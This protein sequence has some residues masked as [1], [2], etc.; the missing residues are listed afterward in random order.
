MLL[1]QSRI[2]CQEVD[3]EYSSSWTSEYLAF[4][5]RM[6]LDGGLLLATGR[7]HS[8][9]RTSSGLAVK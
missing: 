8:V 3:R 5:G 9:S 1:N 2:S 6:T 7:I 4:E